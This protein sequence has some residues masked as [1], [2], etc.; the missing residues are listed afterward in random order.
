MDISKYNSKAWDKEASKENEWSVPVS[1]EKIDLAKKDIWD[2]VLT[3]QK[4]VPRNWFPS[5][6]GKKILALASAGGQ[7]GPIF[8]AAGANVT[9][10]DNSP[11]QLSQDRLVAERDQLDIELVEGDMRDLSLFS[12]EAFDLIFHPCSNCFVPEI[13]PIWTEAYRVLKKGGSLLSG[14]NNP[15]TFSLDPELESKDIL[16]IKYK[17]PYSDLTSLTDE[18]RKRYTDKG[19]PLAF[20]HTLEDQIGGQIDAGFIITGFF[21][22]SSANGPLTRYMNNFIATRALKN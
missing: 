15:I 14:F 3:P 21:E 11:I 10:F 4:S 22:D 13:K 2:V 6:K 12:D 19:E 20:G 1:S 9:V 17:I 8:A 16:Q 7:Q 18:E 5:L